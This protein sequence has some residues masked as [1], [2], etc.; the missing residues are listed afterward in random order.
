[1]LFVSIVEFKKKV[2]KICFVDWNLKRSVYRDMTEKTKAELTLGI[3]VE[4]FS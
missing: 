2:L 4:V 3:K 1:M